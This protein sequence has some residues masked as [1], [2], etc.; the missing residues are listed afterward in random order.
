[1]LIPEYPTGYPKPLPLKRIRRR[2]TS[3]RAIQQLLHARAPGSRG[4]ADVPETGSE[5]AKWPDN[6]RPG[7]EMSASSGV[8]APLEGGGGAGMRSS[9]WMPGGED[10]LRPR[11]KGGVSS[12]RGLTSAGGRN[13]GRD[14]ARAK[15]GMCAVDAGGAPTCNVVSGASLRRRRRRRRRRGGRCI[16]SWERVRTRVGERR[17][18]RSPFQGVGAAAGA[19]WGVWAGR[20]PC[21]DAGGPAD[22]AGVTSIAAAGT[23]G[24]GGAGAAARARGDAMA[25]RGSASR[26][27]A[28]LAW[29]MAAAAG[30]DDGG[31]AAGAGGADLSRC[32]G[33][34]G[35]G[36]GARACGGT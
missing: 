7:V 1:M 32:G 31:A 5:G 9:R 28:T 15:S 24:A 16:P 22:A 3:K 33:R 19:S 27:E 13:A 8:A 35:V 2:K 36:A 21:V 17:R 26:V 23:T 30:P 10:A 12:V 18:R 29:A 4:T 6:A 34:K 20:Q 11:A 14:V 25:R